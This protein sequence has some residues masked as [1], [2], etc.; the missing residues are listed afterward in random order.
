M[1]NQAVVFDLG[2]TLTDLGEGRGSYEARL[3]IRVGKIYDLLADAG[4]KLPDREVFCEGLATGSE[5]QYQAA[6][7]EQRGTDIY[8]VMR[9]FFSLHDISVD[10]ELFEACIQTYGG[11]GGK[12]TPMRHGAMDVLH[13]LRADGYQ[14]GVISNTLQPGRFMDRSLERRGILDFFPARRY[15]ADEGVAKPHPAI[16]RAVLADLNLP[17]EQVVYVGDRLVADVAGAQGVGMKAVLIEVG[18]RVEDDPNI[19][20]DARIKEL[21][22]LLD[23][24]GELL[25]G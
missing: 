20:P 8:E 16:F 19:V 10:D 6:L 17:A 1:R 23:V 15:S 13:S 25:D 22:E 14:L 4:T 9:W 24:L 21:P 7:A 12:P 2:D 3:A 11:G 5:A 18:H